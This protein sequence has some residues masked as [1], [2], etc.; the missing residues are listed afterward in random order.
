MEISGESVDLI[1]AWE[2]GDGDRCSARAVYESRYARPH[3][4]DAEREGLVIGVGYDLRRAASTFE[5]DW[6]TRLDALASTRSA[7]ERLAAYVGKQGSREAVQ[8]TRDVVIPW[9]DAVAVFRL[10]SLPSSIHEAR[11]Q[12][13]GVDTLGPHVWGALTSLLRHCGVGGGGDQR[14]AKGAAYQS[15]RDAVARRDVDAIA[16]AVRLTAGL[17]AQQH[18]TVARAAARRR[19]EEA[20]LVETA[21][22]ARPAA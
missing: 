18:P 7:F 4:R 12:F 21:T 6:K 11:S 22:G 14:A 1:V 15:I 13:P 8:R 3:L 2:V 9:E 5:A 10:R 16:A 17:A 19:E 20:R